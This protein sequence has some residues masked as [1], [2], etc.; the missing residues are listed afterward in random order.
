[1]VENR[2]EELGAHTAPN[3]MSRRTE[4]AAAL[5]MAEQRL[6][7]LDSA[8]FDSSDISAV[9]RKSQ[10]QRDVRIAR[11]ELEDLSGECGNGV[12]GSTQ[13]DRY[14]ELK[15]RSDLAN[16]ETAQ[17][18]HHSRDLSGLPDPNL[19]YDAL[20]NTVGAVWMHVCQI[21]KDEAGPVSKSD[22]LERARWLFTQITGKPP[23]ATWPFF[24]SGVNSER[25]IAA[26]NKVLRT[27][28]AIELKESVDCSTASPGMGALPDPSLAYDVLGD[29]V[30]S[31]WMQVCK[32]LADGAGE[33]PKTQKVEH[34]RWLF[35]AITGQD[36]NTAVTYPLFSPADSYDAQVLTA[37]NTAYRSYWAGKE[38]QGQS[39]DEATNRAESNGGPVDKH[40]AYELNAPW[41]SERGYVETD[42]DLK[43]Y[44]HRQPDYWRQLQGQD[45]E[46]EVG[47]LYMNLG[48]NVRV[49]YPVA[50]DGVDLVVSLRAGV[51]IVQCK[52]EQK[53][54][55]QPVVMQLIGAKLDQRADEA[56]LVSTSG[57]TRQAQHTANRNDITLLGP[58]QL[59]DL[60]DEAELHLLVNGGQRGTLTIDDSPRCMEKDCRKE[61]YRR[62]STP[63]GD[64]WVCS[65]ASCPGERWLP[66]QR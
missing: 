58:E 56:I 9:S 35:R 63:S 45:L 3:S 41:L 16:Q 51:A 1:M 26:A 5:R 11:Q 29:R 4:A 31:V 25:V 32:I 64:W 65:E 24:V 49:T 43:I 14:G 60:G 54:I 53:N 39:A 52:G 13:A 42:G 18:A 34:A 10:L 62:R 6:R 46:M 2:K 61:M 57:F 8:D 37:A 19:A 23:I 33:L 59:A 55:G 27:T 66:A 22:M 17:T 20:G 7:E 30:N 40:G 38:N 48:H 21:V 44:C 36:F 50:D 15:K 28:K 12:H 47:H